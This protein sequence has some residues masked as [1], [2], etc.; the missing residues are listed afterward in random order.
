M[1]ALK[2]LAVLLAGLA[3]VLFG[4]LPA[5]S[6]SGPIKACVGQAGV[7]RIAP[8]LPGERSISWNI[9]GPDG[10]TGPAGQTG[11]VLLPVFSRP[12]APD[13]ALVAYIDAVAWVL[14]SHE[15]EHFRLHE[16]GSIRT[17]LFPP[18]HGELPVYFEGIDCDP[19]AARLLEA[20]TDF[21]GADFPGPVG[22]WIYEFGYDGPDSTTEGMGDRY[23]VDIGAVVE[24]TGYSW[25]EHIGG[26][27]TEC[28]YSGA[29]A[30]FIE[31]TLLEEVQDPG[32]LSVSVVT[33]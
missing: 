7:V 12:P 29:S 32:V 20:D 27:V 3:A 18:A 1:K 8:C 10:M 19:T 4:D 30:S 24:V 5:Q 23:W 15:A 2:S 13:L 16:V 14:Y 17:P 9:P 26:P 31:V 28:W 11:D 22:Q 33:P 21:P 6:A 25:Y